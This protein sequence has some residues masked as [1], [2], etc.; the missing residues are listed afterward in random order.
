MLSF[1]GVALASFLAWSST[2]VTALPQQ[3]TGTSGVAVA[4]QSATLCN[5]SPTL[6]N[7][8]YNAVTHMGAHDS[9]FLRDASTGNSISGNQFLNATVALSSGIRLL[10]A[11][12]HDQNGTLELCHSS[13]QLLDAGS[14][15]AWLEKIAYWMNGNP[16]EVVTLL[17]VN[18][19]NRDVSSFGEVFA[20]SG[21]AKYGYTPASTTATGNWPTLR[22]MISANTRLV[23]FV[24]SI[25]PSSAYPY[26]L[27]EFSYVFETAFGV[28]SAASFNCSL[29]RPASVASAQAAVAGNMMP[30]INHFRD[31]DLGS[32]ILIPDVSDIETTNSPSVITPGALGLHAQ[33]CKTQWG[34]RP[35][36]ILVDF[37]DKGSAIQ[38]ADNLNGLTDVAGRSTSSSSSGSG[39]NTSNSNER[40]LGMGTGALVAFL[41]AALLLF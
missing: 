31:I 37:F 22:E 20:S 25:T 27:P 34:I 26:L 6:C 7:R 14:L 8:T 40:R 39:T 35:T 24:A 11:Q 18:S 33:L 2:T 12:V 19:D 4:A 36:F 13:C 28:T 16:N 10:Q 15:E 30:L 9:A 32:G 17:L 38:T 21:I 41:A 1:L 29:D 23:T 3:A 5:N